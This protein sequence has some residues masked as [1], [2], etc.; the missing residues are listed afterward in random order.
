MNTKTIYTI[1]AIV[2]IAILGYYFINNQ[3][4]V[5]LPGITDNITDQQPINNTVENNDSVTDGYALY[6]NSNYGFSLEYPS[7]WYYDAT[8]TVAVM[9]CKIFNLV[10]TLGSQDPCIPGGTTVYFSD[11][12]GGYCIPKFGCANKDLTSI[13]VDTGK[14]KQGVEFVTMSKIPDE[15]L[16]QLKGYSN[17]DHYT[18]TTREIDGTTIYTLIPNMKDVEDCN[19]ETAFWSRNDMNFS[20]SMPAT[21][22]CRMSSGAIERFEHMVNSLRFL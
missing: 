13:D 20:I 1:L 8:S 22:G 6:T 10:D 14:G 16:S 3:P 5:S 2:V 17:G 19:A 11:W 4:N 12:D 7:H 15:R 9:G 18:Y 21:I